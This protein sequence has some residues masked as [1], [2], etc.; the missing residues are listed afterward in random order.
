MINWY[1]FFKYTLKDIKAG[2]DKHINGIWVFCGLYGSGKTLSL[3]REAYK[4]Y[5]QGYNVYSNYGL[6][7]QNGNI[8]SWKDVIDVPNDSVICLDEISNL[9]NSRDWKNMP[10]E[11]FALLTQN[12]KKNIRLMTTAQVYDD[13]DKQFRTQC[14]WIIQCSKLGRIVTNRYY[15]QKGYNHT[16]EKRVVEFKERYVATDELFALYDTYEYIQKLKKEYKNIN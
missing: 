7:F 14:K 1:N 3:T 8:I 16:E 9:I 10:A 11:F 15:N 5:K 2:K 13:I 12:R 4:L 6:N